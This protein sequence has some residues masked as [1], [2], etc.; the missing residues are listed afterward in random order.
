MHF[1]WL[2]ADDWPTKAHG[3]PYDK[4][5]LSMLL[6]PQRLRPRLLSTAVRRPPPPA[7]AGEH[8]NVFDTW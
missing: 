8:M 2:S 4:T 3:E 5:W 7:P 6:S 1:T